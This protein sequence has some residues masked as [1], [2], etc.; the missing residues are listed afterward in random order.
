[1][2]A[3]GCLKAGNRKT[4]GRPH[5]G[6]EGGLQLQVEKSGRAR[7]AQHLPYPLRYPLHIPTPSPTAFF[8]CPDGFTRDVVLVRL[9]D[10]AQ[11][12]S[13]FLHILKNAEWCGL[14]IWLDV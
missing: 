4:A 9:S 10:M 2:P 1:M 12:N 11:F 3:V 7:V 14:K 13:P 5:E 6:G 8:L